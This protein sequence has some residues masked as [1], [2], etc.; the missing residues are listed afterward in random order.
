M[1]NEY[2]RKNRFDSRWCSATIFPEGRCG[3]NLV[4]IA[5]A[6][7]RFPASPK[8]SITLATQA[9]SEASTKA[10]RIICFPECYVPGYRI[11]NAGQLPDAKFLERWCVLIA[12]A[13]AKD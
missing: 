10:E 11:G 8:E 5:L 2:L 7:V 3:L 6:N 1:A 12:D 13:E 9:M 4:R